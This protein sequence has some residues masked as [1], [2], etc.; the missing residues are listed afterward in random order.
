MNEPTAWNC[1]ICGE[2]VDRSMRFCWQCGSQP[3][4]S[5]GIDIKQETAPV[6]AGFQHR[7]AIQHVLLLLVVFST[8]LGF[9]AVR[10]SPFP[11]LAVCLLGI[12]Y[13]FVHISAWALNQ[14]VVKIRRNNQ[15]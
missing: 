5:K 14:G 7:L 13:C 2:Q 9:F 3:D 12:G 4:G 6:E 15:S 1:L 8:F 11:V 10:N